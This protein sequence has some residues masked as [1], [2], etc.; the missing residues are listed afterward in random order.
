MR[1]AAERS[2][3]VKVDWLVSYPLVFIHLSYMLPASVLA[4][5][6]DIKIINALTKFQQTHTYQKILTAK[7]DLL[8]A[9]HWSHGV[10]SP[11]QGIGGEYAMRS[12][13]KSDI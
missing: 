3:V 13:P 5:S 8:Y 10:T 11:K 1:R 12:N 6:Q 4:K 2:L 7:T 9:S